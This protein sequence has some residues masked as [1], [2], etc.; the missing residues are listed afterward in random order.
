MA[1]APEIGAALVSGVSG[2]LGGAFSGYQS[3]KATKEY[4][5]GQLELAKYQNQANINLWNMQNAYN[6]PAAQMQRYRDAGLNPNLIYGQGSSGNA[7]GIP[8]FSMPNQM[9]RTGKAEAINQVTQAVTEAFSQF[10][11][12][13]QQSEQNKLLKQQVEG[14]RMDNIL[15]GLNAANMATTNSYLDAYLGLRNQ[16][17]EYQGLYNWQNVNYLA[18]TKQMM[19]DDMS[20]R[21]AYEKWFR[22]WNKGYLRRSEAREDTKLNYSVKQILAGIAHMQNQDYYSSQMMPYQQQVLK[23]NAYNALFNAF[24]RINEYE[25]PFDD[26]G[27][28]LFGAGVTGKHVRSIFDYVKGFFRHYPTNYQGGGIR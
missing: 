7:S 12:L 11:S 3:D 16:S 20:D 13:K 22:D 17:M 28:K 1:L 27:F 2:L 8:E 25:H 14:Q 21:Y 24:D 26:L 5:R 10:L 18:A 6:T 23:Y 9:V 15:K 19:I 4:N